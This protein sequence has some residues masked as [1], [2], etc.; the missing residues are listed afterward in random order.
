M[1]RCD[2]ENIVW[3]GHTKKPD[4]DNLKQWFL[5]QLNRNDRIMFI[6]KD[7]ESDDIIG[8]LYLDIVEDNDTVET[9]YGVNSNYKGRG[10]GTKIVKFALE[11]TRNQLKYINEVA[12]WI[13]EDN[14]GSIKVVINNGFY[15]TIDSKIVFIE[16]F[17]GYKKMKKYIYKINDIGR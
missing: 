16:S 17:N 15:E 11:Y 1:L 13:L 8:Y 10:V 2:E 4:K 9:S 6:V 14:I 3:T 12:S 5:S 7:N